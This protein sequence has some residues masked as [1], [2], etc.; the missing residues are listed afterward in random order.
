[1]T[2]QEADTI[3]AYVAQNIVAPLFDDNRQ[4]HEIWEEMTGHQFRDF[5]GFV[6]DF[7][8]KPLDKNP[9]V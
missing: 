6:Y 5:C 7:V 4:G 9:K 1:M 2:K 8:E 3:C